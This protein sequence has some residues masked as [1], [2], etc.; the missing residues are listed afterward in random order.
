MNESK[1]Y[2]P[3]AV[4][5]YFRAA[6]EFWKSN[7]PAIHIPIFQMGKPSPRSPE[8]MESLQMTELGTQS[9]TLAAAMAVTFEPQ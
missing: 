5:I 8:R 1:D 4:N 3:N 7:K 9:A 2:T 6:S